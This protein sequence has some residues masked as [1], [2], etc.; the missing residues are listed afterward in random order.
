MEAAAAASGLAG[1]LLLALNIEI[2]SWG[3]LAFLVSN[4]GWIA[5]AAAGGHW[6]LLAQQLGFLATS[7]IG[8]RNWLL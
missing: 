8:I 3:W 5:F 7:A 6:F 2:S 4:L 1:A